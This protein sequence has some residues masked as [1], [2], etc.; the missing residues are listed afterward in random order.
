MPVL[1]CTV[2]Q[3]VYLQDGFEGDYYRLECEGI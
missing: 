3:K 2:V 1:I